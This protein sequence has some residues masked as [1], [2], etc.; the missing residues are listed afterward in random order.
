MSSLPPHS[1]SARF[2]QNINTRTR[3]AQRKRE[4][5]ATIFD[6]YVRLV[7]ENNLRILGF[8]R[9]N[10]TSLV[11]YGIQSVMCHAAKNGNISVIRFIILGGYHDGVL[12]D[13]LLYAIQ[14]QKWAIAEFLIIKNYRDIGPIKDSDFLLNQSTI[15][16]TISCAIHWNRTYLIELLID[17]DY[18]FDQ[19]QFHALR[20]IDPILAEKYARRHNP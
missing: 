7:N 9:K 17:N 19:S 14:H 16:T 15:S 12:D 4:K 3:F 8:L 6:E 18:E 13:T 20:F 5:L 11:E 1:E 2:I 10:I